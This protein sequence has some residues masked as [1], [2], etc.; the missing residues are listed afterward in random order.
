MKN[1]QITVEFDSAN[2]EHVRLAKEI[3]KPITI[4]L[5]TM[6]PMLTVKGIIGDMIQMEWSAMGMTGGLVCHREFLDLN[7]IEQQIKRQ[8]GDLL[9]PTP[10]SHKERIFE[11]HVEKAYRNPRLKRNGGKKK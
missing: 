5:P 8:A 2:L 7:L 11:H 4:T 1:K 3:L 9:K 10:I 6:G